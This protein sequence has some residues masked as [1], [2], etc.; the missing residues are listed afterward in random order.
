[1]QEILDDVRT[2]QFTNDESGSTSAGHGSDMPNDLH[3]ERDKFVKL[4]RDTEKELYPGCQKFS[5]LSF[6]VVLLHIKLISNW[7][8]NSFDMLLKLLIDAFPLGATIPR[9]FREAKKEHQFKDKCPSC[10]TSR[11]KFLKGNLSQ[12]PHKVLRYFPIKQKLR[13]FF[14]S[15]KIASDMI[16]HKDKRLEEEGVIRHPANSIAWKD[17]DQKHESFASDPRNV[18]LGLASD[19][20]NPFG[21][22]ENFL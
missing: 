4:M 18:R 9:T 22:Y 12:V 10:K 7:S 13:R 3:G 21:K 16:W 19:D 8:N 1:M 2:E 11:Y 17:F 15:R 14:D 5:V 6:T 20:F